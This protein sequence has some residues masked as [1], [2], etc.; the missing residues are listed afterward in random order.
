MGWDVAKGIAGAADA[1]AGLIG[2]SIKRE[3]DLEQSR[4]LLTMQDQIEQMKQQRIADVIKNAP[5][6]VTT[7]VDDESGGHTTTRAMTSIERDRARGEALQNAGLIQQS[8]H[9]LDRAER[10]EDKDEDRK[11]RSAKQQSDDEK[12][13]KTFEETA[14]HH[15]QLEKAAAA[16]LGL[17]EAEKKEFGQAVDSYV[18]AKANLDQLKLM[19]APQDQ[20]D[21]MQRGVDSAALRLQQWK[22]N[23]GDSSDLSK[24]M[25]LSAS[26]SA[27]D[28]TLSDPM[29]KPEDKARAEAARSS[30]LDT[31]NAITSKG[32]DKGDAGPVAFM[33]DPKTGKLVPTSSATATAAKPAGVINSQQGP[34][35]KNK[36]IGPPF[37]GFEA[38]LIGTEY[39]TGK[40]LPNVREKL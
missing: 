8:Q 1:G 4:N 14:R 38:N 10:S 21:A 2:D 37:T 39:G 36:L 40:E 11:V 26:L 24:H 27:I 3:R 18:G 22:V 9:F 32:K 33:K 25:S 17:K 6:T 34:D 20:I 15:K 35:G 7:A 29:L 28:K 13:R 12:W 19:K 16:Q 31:I 23:V 30:V 5:S